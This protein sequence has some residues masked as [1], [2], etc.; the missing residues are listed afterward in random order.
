MQGGQKT[1][2]GPKADGSIWSNLNRLTPK[3]YEA[4]LNDLNAF[5][6]EA[7]KY[8]AQVQNGDWNAAT[9]TFIT[10]RDKYGDDLRFSGMLHSLREPSYG[11]EYTYDERLPDFINNLRNDAMDMKFKKETRDAYLGI[12]EHAY[13]VKSRWD[14]LHSL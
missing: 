2:L 14:K 1:D 10:M 6:R 13:N 8:N 11:V 4:L 3:Q 7:F 5:Q 12:G 9:D